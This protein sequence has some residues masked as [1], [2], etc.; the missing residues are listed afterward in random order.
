MLALPQ[1]DYLRALRL[2]RAALDETQPISYANDLLIY[3]LQALGRYAEADGLKT[4]RAEL[5]QQRGLADLPPTL[6]AAIEAATAASAATGDRP[7]A[8]P[9]ITPD[10]AAARLGQ[11]VPERRILILGEEHPQ[12]EHRLLG[13]RLLP[14]LRAAGITHLALETGAQ[15]PLDEARRTGRVTPT[16]DGFSFEPQRAGLLRAALGAD[17]PIVAFDLD[18]EDSAWLQAHPEADLF[19][20]R[21]RRMAEHITERILR[22]EPAARVLVWVGHGHGQ[23]G[24]PVKMMAQYLWELAGEEPYAVYQLTGPGNR[25]G[26]DLL[27][28]HPQPSYTRQRPDWLRQAD[29]HAIAGRIQPPGACLVQLHLAAEGAAGTPVDQLLTDADGGFELLVPAGDYLLRLWSATDERLTHTRPL[30]VNGSIADLRL[31]G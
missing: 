6:R 22:P 16:T 3:V 18:R 14:H 25:P 20:E 2:L 10:G 28:R 24:T 21:E 26:V 12:P 30:T 5:E 4:R 23:K 29:R 27:I 13:A 17:L 9:E 15:A 31:P 8:I 19:I 1:G 11:V 7:P